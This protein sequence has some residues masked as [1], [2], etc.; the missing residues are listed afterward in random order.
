MDVDVPVRIAADHPGMRFAK[1]RTSIRHLFCRSTRAFARKQQRRIRDYFAVPKDDGGRAYPWR[2]VLPGGV[3]RF[4]L[5]CVTVVPLL[6]QSAR[7]YRRSGD[8]AA[9][10]HPVACWLTLW[11]YGTNLIFARGKAQSRRGWRQ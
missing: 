5:A 7:A 8:G 1:V 2:A 3:V 6:V 10:F 11:V 9:F 4:S